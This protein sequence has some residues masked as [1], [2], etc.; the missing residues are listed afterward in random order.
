[1]S[2]ELTM[3]KLGLTMKT[4]KLARW[5][6]AEGAAVRQ[7]D[8][9]FEVETD[10]I[11]NKIESPADGVLL[12]VL[13]PQ[14]ETVPVGTVVGV[15][16]EP[17]EA[18]ATA[19]AP[20]QASTASDEPEKAEA[21]PKQ[22]AAQ[23]PAGFVP[24]TPRARSLAGFLELNLSLVKGTGPD[25][26][27]RES[28]VLARH[29]AL[30]PAVIT[31]L[32]R[33]VAENA[34]I[35]ALSLKGTGERGK[36]VREDVERA[37]N[38]D[39]HPAA[40]A[41]AAAPAGP[42]S[43]PRTRTVSLEGGGAGSPTRTLVL[44]LDMGQA[45]ALAADLKRLGGAYKAVADAVSA[46]LVVVAALA[47]SLAAHPALNAT[48]AD[49]VLTSRDTVALKLRDASSGREAVI[50]DAAGKG[51]LALAADRG[52]G[53]AGDATCV[54]TSF[55][56]TFVEQADPELP[57]GHVLALCLGAQCDAHGHSRARL[58]LAYDTRLADEAEVCAFADDLARNVREPERMLF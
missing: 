4:G 40:A 54:L 35:D 14:G 8:D 38:P 11:T 47:R 5:L 6:V 46:E 18:P 42:A 53:A 41:E 31:P 21:A 23:A 43:A 1:M 28:D 33:S 7:G 56:G 19:G 9:I 55:A 15:L 24:A 48:W 3:P 45:G 39:A 25:G 16:G 29:D 30:N 2:T 22:A 26:T 32:A 57:A 44:G 13:V 49:G 37:L 27:V 17:G 34:G 10:K 20:A 50:A 52:A 36:I 58:S 12:S 51:L